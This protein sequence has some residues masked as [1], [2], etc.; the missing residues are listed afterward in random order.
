M[1]ID[2][3]WIERSKH[4]FFTD[5]EIRST[6]TAYEAAQVLDACVHHATYTD[7]EAVRTACMHVAQ[8]LNDILYPKTK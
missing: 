1:K 7:H 2:S 8:A 6:M 3:A 4:G 5:G